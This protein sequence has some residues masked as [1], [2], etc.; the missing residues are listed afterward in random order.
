M[1]TNKII[2]TAWRTLPHTCTGNSN[3]YN[4]NKIKLKRNNNIDKRGTNQ[5]NKIETR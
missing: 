1:N 3:T 4:E 5:T 2:K